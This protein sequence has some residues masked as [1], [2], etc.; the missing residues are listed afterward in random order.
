[1]NTDTNKIIKIGL[2]LSLLLLTLASVSATNNTEYNV[3]FNKNT[4]DLAEG[5]KLTIIKPENTS[6]ELTYQKI[7]P[8]IEYEPTTIHILENETIIDIKRSGLYQVTSRLLNLNNSSMLNANTKTNLQN[9]RFQINTFD[10]EIDV[11][12]TILPKNNNLKLEAKTSNTQ[13]A[14]TYTWT[15][16]DGTGTIKTGRAV[17]HNFP[18][19]GSH[20]V[21][22][23][24]E[25]E[26]GNKN[27]ATRTINV[28]DAKI[29]WVEVR[30]EATNELIEDAD[31]DFGITSAKTDNLGRA[32]FYLPVRTYILEVDKD[33]FRQTR[34][35]VDVTRDNTYVVYLGRDR[36]EYDAPAIVADTLLK[37][38]V[39]SD[40]AV[41]EYEVYDENPVRC[42]VYL[43]RE[44]TAW[45]FINAVEVLG[46]TKV[47]K[48]EFSN[49]KDTR[50]DWRIDCEDSQGNRAVASSFFNV[51]LNA[52][53]NQD[54]LNGTTS[55]ES[56]SVQLDVD[57]TIATKSFL[58]RISSARTSLSSGSDIEKEVAS[59]LEL[60]I[61]L[62]IVEKDLRAFEE[63][64]FRLKQDGSTD[65]FNT[66]LVEVEDVVSTKQEE[67]IEKINIISRDD[68]VVES[69][70]SLFDAHYKASGRDFSSKNIE[71]EIL[72]VQADTFSGASKYYTFIRHEGFEDK[73]LLVVNIPASIATSRSEIRTKNALSQ[74][75]D[76]IIEFT[77]RNGEVLFFVERSLELS[78]F[79]DYD[80]AVVK[81]RS[82]GSS[83]TGR[84]I[85]FSSENLQSYI[86]F[87]LIGALG[88][89]Y[90]VYNFELVDK[91]KES[92]LLGKYKSTS[93]ESV[94]I[95]REIK[96]AKKIAHENIKDAED[97]YN[98]IMIKY[99]GLTHDER[100]EIYDAAL[101]LHS[102]LIEIKIDKLQELIEACTFRKDINGANFHLQEIENIYKNLSPELKD[103]LKYKTILAN[104]NVRGENT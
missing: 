37:S 42:E 73:E 19:T 84:S 26:Y 60:E 24:V 29:I 54:S 97:T 39:K 47:Y 15:F 10:V 12:R 49:L 27:N 46:E 44:D 63:S 11:E 4:Y 1:M 25:D 59:I 55:D 101:S 96:K 17:N 5:M 69:S 52:T 65:G 93:K 68:L 79:S 9:D 38:V 53:A 78:S 72:L 50:Y 18:N 75:S 30:S 57:H 41:L 86:L 90:V 61:D 81:Q 20:S 45:K 31:V 99:Q 98:K 62:N 51:D 87:I 82:A 40:K 35:Y 43:K 71:T 56:N 36:D 88:I 100:R 80:L 22:V 94:E 83:A 103:K 92:D 95:K 91:I 70:K 16:N 13:G 67:L 33:K 14:V 64:L 34:Q 66:R 102:T 58:E 21:L 74:V 2:I 32:L 76:M 7:H 3:L 28:Q 23:E 6:V 104:F 85:S 8:I 89:F 48:T 77:P